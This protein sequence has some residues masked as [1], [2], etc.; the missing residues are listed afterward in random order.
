MSLARGAGIYRIDR[1][2][3]RSLLPRPDQARWDRQNATSACHGRCTRRYAQIIYLKS[4]SKPVR[5]RIERY[6]PINV[7][8]RQTVL[9]TIMVELAFP[10]F[11]LLILGS[12]LAWGITEYV[13]TD[14]HRP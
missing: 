12:F 13:R 1:F 10:L 14:A 3:A 2:A 11:N 6:E 5:L 7:A 8:T 4:K 9:E